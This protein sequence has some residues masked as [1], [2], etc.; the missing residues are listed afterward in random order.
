VLIP[1]LDNE[2]NELLERAIDPKF[3]D[4]DNM[5]DIFGIIT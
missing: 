2:I 1:K 4:G 3:L 5:D